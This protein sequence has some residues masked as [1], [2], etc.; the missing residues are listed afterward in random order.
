VGAAKL[1]RMVRRVNHE[2]HTARLA[3]RAI[4]PVVSR[5]AFVLG[6]LVTLAACNRGPKLETPVPGATPLAAYAT[7]RIALTP[8]ALVR[9]DSLGWVQALGGA[10]AV[11]RLADSVILAALTERAI[12]GGWVLPTELM[13]G[14]ERNRN[15]AANPYQLSVEPLRAPKF[16]ALSRYGEPLASQLRSMIA[17]HGDARI[18]V[19]PV[20]VR[21]ERV[22]GGGR[23][24]LRVAVLD[25]RFAEARWVGELTGD[26]TSVPARALAEVG[27]RFADL[28]TA[29]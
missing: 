29:P 5:S 24:V 1:W 2:S 7:Q 19:L 10:Q 21:F 26:S 25:P 9:A 16:V 18:V 20:E 12:G 8:T 13:R 28:F 11:R 15:Y 6:V 14:Y 22:A 17:L 27:R 23:S 3:N 4:F